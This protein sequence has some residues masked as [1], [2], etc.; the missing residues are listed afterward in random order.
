MLLQNRCAARG[1][2]VEEIA[3]SEDSRKRLRILLEDRHF[4][5][6]LL[7]DLRSERANFGPLTDETAE[8]SKKE[9]PED[10]TCAEQQPQA[11][12][13]PLNGSDWR[14]LWQRDGYVLYGADVWQLF[15]NEVVGKL[16]DPKCITSRDLWEAFLA[17]V[18][19]ISKSSALET[20][21]ARFVESSL[22]LLDDFRIR[23]SVLNDNAFGWD[24]TVVS[25]PF[26]FGSWSPQPED[27]P[28]EPE[29]RPATVRPGSGRRFLFISAEGELTEGPE[30]YLALYPL[31]D[32]NSES[33]YSF[34]VGWDYHKQRV[35]G[36]LCGD[37]SEKAFQNAEM[38]FRCFLPSVFGS[39]LVLE[40]A[41]GGVK[42]L[43][44]DTEEHWRL[45][46]NAKEDVEKLSYP[47]FAGGFGRTFFARCVSGYFVKTK[48]KGDMD[49][50]IGNAVRML[51]E[52]DAQRSYT[53]ALA[54]CFT[55]I[56]AIVCVKTEGITEELANNATVALEAEPRQRD[57]AIEAI[58]ALYR[59][60]S[61]AVHG[62]S[63]KQ[64]QTA[65]RKTRRLAAA[66]L[67]A[68][69]E[70][71][72]HKRQRGDIAEQREFAKDLKKAL[73]TGSKVVGV[74]ERF[75]VAERL[76]ACLPRLEKEG[77]PRGNF[78]R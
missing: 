24:Q 38:E 50:R 41:V 63:I 3:M 5:K 23:K 20:A 16:P 61:K 36:Y 30:L 75:G 8:S 65:W 44:D 9:H 72:S 71:S 26:D 42:W 14:E 46:F 78:R 4:K 66:V 22:L 6:R 70:W 27:E 17:Q 54:L 33:G 57:G 18:G 35:E 49:S 12:E 21:Y 29:D 13:K 7:S 10:T 45:P 74:G 25:D 43:D 39:F 34:Y 77:K 64:D 73:R 51:V 53:V 59:L 1:A 28:L 15:E 62:E 68:A 76:R 40:D 58:R 37:A 2:V 11:S 55:A 52:A 56:E 47:S 60:R 67:G 69:T 19:G 31:W 32:S 48:K